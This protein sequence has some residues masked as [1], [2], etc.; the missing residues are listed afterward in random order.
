[1]SQFDVHRNPGRNQGAIPYVVVVQSAAFDRIGRRLVVPLLAEVGVGAR[2]RIPFSD[3]TPGLTVNGQQLVLN[4]FELVSV[5]AARLGPVVASL[6][7][8]GD[9]IVAALDEVF[10]R[11]HG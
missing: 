4:P 1:M 6:A 8:S 3:S 7:D 2:I 9:H 10:S 5:E 11:A